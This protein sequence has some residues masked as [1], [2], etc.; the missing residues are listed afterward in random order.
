MSQ[1]FYLIPGKGMPKKEIKRRESI[2]NTFLN[3]KT[4]NVF[5][6]ESGEGPESIE[7][8]LERE[9]SVHGMINKLIEKKDQA[10]AAIIGC[11]SDPGLFSLRE[12]FDIPIVGPLESSIALSMLL[13]DKFSIITILESAYPR[14]RNVLRQY[15]ILNKCSSIRAINYSVADLNN[16]KISKDDIVNAFIKEANN[17]VRDGASSVIMGCMSMAFH[18]LDE[19]AGRKIDI[20]VI[21]PAKTSIKMAELLVSMGFIHSRR[22]YPKANKV[23]LKNSILPNL[24]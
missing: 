24:L 2:A 14:I 12:L 1:I 16:E 23:K 9:L 11:A 10:D 8:S 21:N 7:S 3:D 18:L 20:P 6:D 17:A 4:N 5:A 19:E 22:A 15:E 13:G